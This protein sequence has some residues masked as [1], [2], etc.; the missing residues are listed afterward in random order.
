MRKPR[1]IEIGVHAHLTPYSDGH[2]LRGGPIPHLGHLEMLLISAI[3]FCLFPRP[4]PPCP[5]HSCLCLCCAGAFLHKMFDKNRGGESGPWETEADN[6]VDTQ[7]QQLC[8]DLE[9]GRFGAVLG[10]EW[11]PAQRLHLGDGVV[12]FTP[13]RKV[14]FL[15]L[16]LEP[17]PM[18]PAPRALQ[19][20]KWCLCLSSCLCLRK[21]L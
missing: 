12:T 2:F 19:T 17:P 1:P 21:L 16:E 14:F 13:R 15:P 9:D 20:Q 3:Y 5:H 11:W 8:Q 7:L 18:P 10:G 4:G 6:R